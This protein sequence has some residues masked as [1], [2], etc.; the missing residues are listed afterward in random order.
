M[1]WAEAITAIVWPRTGIVLA[2][3]I[4]WTDVIKA[5]AWP[6]TVLLIISKFENEIR[7]LINH[8]KISLSFGGNKVE[9]SHAE[10]EQL[11]I[12]QGS[13]ISK[14]EAEKLK[15][16]NEN[17]RGIEK[18]LLELNE[19]T[20][21]DKDAF[22]LGYHFEK[23]YR[24]IFGSQLSILKIANQTGFVQDPLAAAIYGRTSWANTYPY[25]DY[26][27]FLISSGLLGKLDSSNESYSIL[28]FGKAFIDYL[29]NSGIPLN[30]QP[31]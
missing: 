18:K 22:F 2:G 7:E 13:A 15:D 19:N 4:N 10:A 12:D 11:R 17:H 31:Y 29:Q 9:I 30:K 1:N 28:P 26:I 20:T 14:E 27:G 23:T 5:I 8:I 24:L 16:E 25:K 3:Q 21:K 6:G